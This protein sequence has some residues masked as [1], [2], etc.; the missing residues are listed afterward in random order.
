MCVCG[1]GWK[2]GRKVG[3]KILKKYKIFFQERREEV[4][5]RPWLY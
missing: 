1:L 2:V 3:R 5:F 4:F